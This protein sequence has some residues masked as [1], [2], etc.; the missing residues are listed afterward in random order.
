M[1]VTAVASYVENRRVFFFRKKVT[2][3][4]KLTPKLPRNYPLFTPKCPEVG[5][6]GTRT[7][8]M[9]TDQAVLLYSAMATNRQFVRTYLVHTIDCTNLMY[10]ND[11]YI[12]GILL[13]MADVSVMVYTRGKPH[14]SITPA[15]F[16]RFICAHANSI[17]SHRRTSWHLY[18]HAKTTPSH[19]NK[20]PLDTPKRVFHE[21]MHS[22]T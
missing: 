18:I 4:S 10:A 19:G 22:I 20:L 7:H 9:L 14:S 5:A 6:N 17:P 8:N 21:V 15:V 12:P 1:T 11:T 2:F 13:H 3:S 16:V